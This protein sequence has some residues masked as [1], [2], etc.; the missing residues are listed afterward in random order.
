[1]VDPHPG[2]TSRLQWLQLTV[3][4]MGSIHTPFV[5][6][7]AL[8]ADM[9]GRADVMRC[10]L[11]EGVVSAP[12]QRKSFVCCYLSYPFLSHIYTRQRNELW[13]TH[14]GE[15]KDVDVVLVVDGLN[16]RKAL[17]RLWSFILFG[18]CLPR[19]IRFERPSVLAVLEYGSKSCDLHNNQE[20][21]NAVFVDV[22]QPPPPPCSL[23]ACD[24]THTQTHTI[25]PPPSCRLSPIAP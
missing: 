19:E 9:I 6:C 5:A 10:A 25:L 14:Q 7:V 15:V 22:W 2:R 1:M 24:H 3:G 17:L 18:L 12:P 13:C 21:Y 4:H 23:K 20:P 11:A 16:G 8:C